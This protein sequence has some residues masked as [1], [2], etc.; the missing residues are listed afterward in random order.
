MTNDRTLFV[1]A[2]LAGGLARRMGGVDKALQSVGGESVLARLIARLRPQAASLILNINGDASRFAGFG[3][4]VV[5]DD[6]PG[7]PGPLAGV[8]ASLDW[9]AQ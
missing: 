9:T 8:L 2:I 1:G 5:T 6:L 4:P 3:L 7:H